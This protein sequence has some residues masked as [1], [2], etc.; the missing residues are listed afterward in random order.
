[1]IL[2]H[3]SIGQIKDNLIPFTQTD[4][5]Y[6]DALNRYVSFTSETEF[7]G[8]IE[9][10]KRT[11]FI[12]ANNYLRIPEIQDDYSIQFLTHVNRK[13]YIKE[14]NGELTYIQVSALNIENGKFW[15]KI[16]PGLAK[17][18]GRKG[19]TLTSA[20][21]YYIYYAFHQNKLVF[22]AIDRICI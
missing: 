3:L 6:I 16:S 10:G 2:S 20:C 1:M 22:A 9:N 21:D 8:E 11:L 7:S 18:K 15:I 14:R 4:S 17:L 19:M 12:E 13:K 5:L